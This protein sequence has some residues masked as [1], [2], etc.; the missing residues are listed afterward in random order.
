MKHNNE[1]EFED[2]VTAEAEVESISEIRCPLPTQRA[3]RSV[4]KSSNEDYIARGY[5]V[6]VSNDGVTYSEED[7]LVIHD[8]TCVNCS[9]DE[10]S[11]TICIVHV[12][13]FQ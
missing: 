13:I 6:S 7:F 9:V 5:Y 11:G 3:R 1:F 8:S 10:T 12:C 4:E 2:A